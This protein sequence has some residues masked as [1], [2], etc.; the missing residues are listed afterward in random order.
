LTTTRHSL[1][2][3]LSIGVPTCFTWAVASTSKADLITIRSDS[4]WRTT[5]PQPGTGWNTDPLF[6]DSDAAVTI[7]ECVN[8][9]D[10]PEA[11]AQEIESL[12]P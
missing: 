4:T 6:D 2:R 1:P 10:R 12:S 9:H 8:A 7:L 3:H 11:G 5:T